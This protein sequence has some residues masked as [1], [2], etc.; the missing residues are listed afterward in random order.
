MYLQHSCTNSCEIF[1]LH[2][3]LMFENDIRQFYGIVQLNFEVM[4]LKQRAYVCMYFF[5]MICFL[6]M[7]FYRL[8]NVIVHH[9]QIPNLFA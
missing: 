9:Y 8:I 4:L 3:Y 7:M 5:L 6:F 2:S 1:S